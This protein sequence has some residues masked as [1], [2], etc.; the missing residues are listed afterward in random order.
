[1]DRKL[2]CITGLDGTGKSTL[3]KGIAAKYKSHYVA[4]IWDLMTKPVEGL[5]FKSKQEIDGFLCS[6][7][8]DSRLLF[9]GHAMK[10]AIDKAML[11]KVDLIILDSYFY[12]YFATE[13][14][15]GANSSLIA[16]LIEVFPKPDLVI[17]L[18][19][20]VEEASLR[21]KH[22]S[23]YECGLTRD[24]NKQN[25]VD[26]QSKVAKEWEMYDRTNWKLIDASQSENDLLMQVLEVLGFN[27]AL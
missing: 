5:P 6:L 21:K 8:P 24:C 17:Q 22:F 10:Y 14:A 1:M 25:F 2:V 27:A 18:T 19:L 16:H 4:N 7:T 9:L 26:F 11:E 15:L 23:R 3:I 12:K 20:P 13:K